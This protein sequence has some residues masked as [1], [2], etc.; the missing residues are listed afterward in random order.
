MISES[1]QA[2][3]DLAN[4]KKVLQK[5][6]Q[7][8]QGFKTRNQELSATVESL[9]PDVSS[10]EAFRKKGISTPTFDTESNALLLKVEEIEANFKKN[11]EMILSSASFKPQQF[12]A[13]VDSFRHAL[14][15]TTGLLWSEYT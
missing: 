2:M 10:L 8:L 11:P 5:Q 4:R 9:R 6:V 7:Q 15:T 1:A 13:T 14:S 3:I 12:F